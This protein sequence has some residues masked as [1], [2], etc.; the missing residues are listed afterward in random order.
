MACCSRSVFART[1]VFAAA[2]LLI[3]VLEKTGEFD[4]SLSDSML[5]IEDVVIGGGMPFDKLL[6]LAGLGA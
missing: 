2:V 4:L 1:A 3:A 6:K 5:V